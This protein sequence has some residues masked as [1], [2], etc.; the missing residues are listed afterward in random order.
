VAKD[1]LG[2]VTQRQVVR[3]AVVRVVQGAVVQRQVVRGAVVQRQ[4]VRGAVVRG[5]V[6]SGWLCWARSCDVRA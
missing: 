1:V 6:R 2:A 5:Q 3:G 4:V